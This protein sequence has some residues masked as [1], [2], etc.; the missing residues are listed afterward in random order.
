MPMMSAPR[1]PS[2]RSMLFSSASLN[3]T[4]VL[5]GSYGRWPPSEPGRALGVVAGAAFGAGA[6]RPCGADCC[7]FDC[8]CCCS[9]VGVG[10]LV[11]GLPMGT[12]CEICIVL[13]PLL[14]VPAVGRP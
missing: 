10:V 11:C 13:G 14:T 3:M 8:C 12:G 1:L 4:S 7:G 9:C 2:V 5:L 6:S